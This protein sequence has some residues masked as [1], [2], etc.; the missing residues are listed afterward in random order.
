MKKVE[1]VHHFL[2]KFKLP[3]PLT[4]PLGKVTAN[5]RGKIQRGTFE[6]GTLSSFKEGLIS[7]RCFCY[8]IFDR[9]WTGNIPLLLLGTYSLPLFSAIM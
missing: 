5:L 4:H 1:L 7:R 2:K 8:I 9:C 3:H 6:A